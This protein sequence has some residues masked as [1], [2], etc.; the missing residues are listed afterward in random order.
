MTTRAGGVSADPYDGFNL[1]DH[2]GDDP[3]AVAANRA[4]LAERIGVPSSALVFMEQVHGARVTVVDQPVDG[5]VPASDGLVTATPGL[6]LAALAADCVPVLLS[7]PDA[8]VVAA[9]HAGRPGARAGVVPAA[10][11]VMAELGAEPARMEALLGP[12]VCGSCYEVPRDMRADVNEHLPGST[13][14]TSAGSSGL[15]LRAGLSRQLVDAGIGAVVTDP[16]CTMED[17]DLYSFRRDKVT[18]R[19]AGLVW[20]DG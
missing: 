4:S 9:V 12:A 8:G 17:P 13:C 1:G 19:H 11:R 14:V 5:P 7:D 20:L 10:L 15:D 18:G 2:V 6:V 3:A 16:R